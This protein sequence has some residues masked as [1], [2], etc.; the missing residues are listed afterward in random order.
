[1]SAAFAASAVFIT[2][3]PSASA[4]AFELDP[5]Y[6]PTI[7]SQPLSLRFPGMR[8]PLA[9]VADDGDLLALEQVQIGVRF[10]VH[11]QC[12][13]NPLRYW[14]LGSRFWVLGYPA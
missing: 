3:R 10:V 8:V 13:S 5:G 14:V 4:F 12:Q 1:M 9:A 11:L 2:V 7:T 6:S